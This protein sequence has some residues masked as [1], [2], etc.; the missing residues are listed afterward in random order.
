MTVSPSD[1][2][3]QVLSRQRHEPL[4]RK[5]VGNVR[6]DLTGD[7]ETEHWLIAV[8]RGNMRVSHDTEEVPAD[9]VLTTRRVV[10]D[11]VVTGQKN[12]MAAMLRGLITVEGD[13]E[14][15]LL[16]ARLFP[17]AVTGRDS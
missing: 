3:F 13:P 8:D 5:A 6:I 7:G 15:L 4:L 2:F 17:G 10:F 14:L 16:L 9:C 12:A 1:T 11:E